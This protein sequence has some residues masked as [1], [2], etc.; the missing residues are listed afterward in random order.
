S[1]VS[2]RLNATR[3]GKNVRFPRWIITISTLF[4][5]GVDPPFPLF[6]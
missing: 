4:R 2:L 6:G 3:K 1:V 5:L